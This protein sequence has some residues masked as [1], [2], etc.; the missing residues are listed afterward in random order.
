MSQ[1][2]NA[3]S[4][5][6]VPGNAEKIAEYISIFENS[7]LFDRYFK[8][9][10]EFLDSLIA[11]VNEGN[12][13]IAENMDGEAVGFMLFNME[14]MYGKLPYLELLG[15]KEGYRDMG[16]G[17]QLIDIFFAIG[18]KLGHNRFFISASDFNPRAKALYHRKG[19]RTLC[20]VPELFKKGINEW[21]LIRE[22]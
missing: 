15:V 11:P 8:N 14:G 13:V 9:N 17:A 7:D 4:I 1:N 12:T 22:F 5:R 21:L 18:Q 16:I 10:T 6:F 20:L 19:F 2:P 3:D